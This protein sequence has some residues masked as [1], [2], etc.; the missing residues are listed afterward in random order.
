MF[1]ILLCLLCLQNS[2]ALCYSEHVKASASGSEASFLSCV[3]MKQTAVLSWG[4]FNR[5]Q[6]VSLEMKED[7]LFFKLCSSSVTAHLI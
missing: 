6:E 5:M 2:A 3:W 1:P 7:L 4:A